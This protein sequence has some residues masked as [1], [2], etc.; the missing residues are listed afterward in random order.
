[1]DPIMRAAADLL[2]TE[3]SA[4]VDL[5]GSRRS[6][7]LRC[8]TAEGDSVIVKS[9]SGEPEAL[10]CFASE[11]AGL[12]LGLA[13]PRLLGVDSTVPLV[14]MADLGDAPSLADVL[15]GRDP[16]AAAEGLLTWARGLGR[17]AA[18]SVRRRADLARL[19][20]RYGGG[21]RAPEDEPWMQESAAALLAQLAEA[22][23]AAPS[24]L[25][26]ELEEIRTVVG[27]EYPAFTPGDT[28]ADNNLLTPEG[29]R[30][31]DFEAACFQSVFLTAAYCRMPFATC[32]CVFRIPA[33][34]AEEVEDAF[35]AEVVTA[36][37]ALAG[38]AVW[39]AG[40]RRAIAVWTVFMTVHLL[41][42]TAQDGPMHRTRRPVPTRRQVL[43]YRW[44]TAAAIEEYPA[45]AETMR[46][47]LREIAG[48]WRDTPPLPVYPAF[49]GGETG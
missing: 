3:L 44:E 39:Q 30:L 35:R 21:M 5:G 11:A 13:G 32:W 36:Y 12:S 1:M 42:R 26:G 48:R 16:R 20:A 25:A 43:R 15:L 18:G 8:R 23:I 10:R 2:A 40:M 34:P 7:V 17:L 24:G 37:P 41:P 6:T 9:F 27:K 47:L 14:V 31:I 46:L 4:P 28:C 49:A 38:D 22:G 19:W 33:G 45:F 29:L